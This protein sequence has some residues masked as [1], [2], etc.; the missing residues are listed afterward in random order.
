MTDDANEDIFDESDVCNDNTNEES[1]WKVIFVLFCA[2]TLCYIIINEFE[3]CL[4]IYFSLCFAWSMLM[5]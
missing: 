1:D 4:F 3:M 2:Q 5:F